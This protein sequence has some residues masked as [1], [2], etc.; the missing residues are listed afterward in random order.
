MDKS[1]A[2]S[3]L[4]SHAGI[5]DGPRLRD[6]IVGMLRPFV[7]VEE[8]NFHE[9]VECIFLLHDEL[10]SD[11]IDTAIPHSLLSIIAQLTGHAILPNS[12]LRRNSLM[13]ESDVARMTSW[14][15]IIESASLRYMMRRNHAIALSAYL[16]YLLLEDVEQ[17]ATHAA[18][19]AAIVDSFDQDDD[20]KEIAINVCTKCRA[21]R[22]CFKDQI[23]CLATQK[24][25]PELSAAILK[26]QQ[27]LDVPCSS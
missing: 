19:F 26:Y 11:K 9:V 23:S 2:I 25:G 21:A 16:E 14:V 17:F 1:E 22:H 5:A 24:V 15:N 3:I 13:S 27:S 8:R 20:Y 7:G 18:M 6:G 10:K 12:M 4:Q